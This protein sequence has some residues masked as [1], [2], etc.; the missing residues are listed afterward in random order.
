MIPKSINIAPSVRNA[1]KDKKPVVALESTVLTH[2]L[3]YPENFSIFQTLENLLISQK[4]TPATIIV[5]DGIAYIGLEENMQMKLKQMLK[6]KENFSKLGMRDLPL[7]IAKEISGGTTVSATMLLAHLAG[8]KVFATGGIGGVHRNWE[9][10]LD[11]SSD[12]IALSRIPVIVISAGCKAILDIP[13]TLE[14]LETLAIPILGWKTNSFPLFYTSKSVYPIEKIDN[15]DIFVSFWKNH[16]ALK[17]KGI[18]IANPI[19]EE[20]SLPLDKLDSIINESI[21]QA[22]IKGI[23]GK[24]LTPFLLDFL[25]QATKGESIKANLAL[26]KNN[27]Q[28]AAELAKALI[29]K[30]S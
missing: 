22:Q 21:E 3:P 23:K 19:P 6:N 7:A 9:S 17:G 20:Y 24:E 10:S 30:G 12:L 5:L 29:N 18:L 13:A 4:V 15:L 27:V 14:V 2:G 28:L 25:A 26:L 1:L 16:L 11:I 8:I